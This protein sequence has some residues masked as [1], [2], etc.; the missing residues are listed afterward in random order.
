MNTLAIRLYQSGAAREEAVR[1]GVAGEFDGLVRRYND[2]SIPVHELVGFRPRE[3]YSCDYHTGGSQGERLRSICKAQRE[4]FA[5]VLEL[6]IAR[7]GQ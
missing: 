5:R 3:P 6:A 7:S 2:A 1:A 4:P